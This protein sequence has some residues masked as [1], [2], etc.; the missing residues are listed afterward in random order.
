MKLLKNIKNLFL[1]WSWPYDYEI[2]KLFGVNSPPS[3]GY[4]SW[5]LTDWPIL[6][7]L[8]LCVIIPWTGILTFFTYNIIILPIYYF[9]F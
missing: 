1:T 3:K 4:Y 9:I 8:F 5:D 2:R 6:L 7:Y